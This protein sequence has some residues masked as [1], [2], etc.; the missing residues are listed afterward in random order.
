MYQ[1]AMLFS[2]PETAA[3]VLNEFSPR[4]VRSLGRQ[5]A[6]FD[7]ST[8]HANRERIVTAGTRLKFTR[9]VNEEGLRRGEAAEA[10]LVAPLTLRGLLLSTG[11]REIVEASPM[12]RIW[13]VGFGAAK[14]EGN[15]ARWGL[16]LLGKALMVVREE[17]RREDEGGAEARE[18]K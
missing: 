16:N 10:P 7:D 12:D 9:A 3:L 18:E 5:V 17:F 15:R 6:N 11:E 4:Q 1:K 8:W 2:D 14:A 13:G